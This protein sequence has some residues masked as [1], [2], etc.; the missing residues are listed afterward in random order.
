MTQYY[1][2]LTSAQV[3]RVHE[4]SLEILDEVGLLIRNA[5]AREILAA[6][7]CKPQPGTEIMHFPR[8]VVEEFRASIPPT[9]TFGGRDPSFDRTIPRR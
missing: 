3:Q 5:R 1:E 6:H 4:A 7:G 8:A 2:L 9:F